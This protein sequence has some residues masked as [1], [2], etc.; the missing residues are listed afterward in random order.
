MT[1]LMKSSPAF[2][3]DTNHLTRAVLVLFL[4]AVLSA[5]GKSSKTNGFVVIHV[6]N[7]SIEN[8]ESYEYCRIQ[9]QTYP[10][11]RRL[12]RLMRQ[13]ERRPPEIPDGSNYYHISYYKTE[14]PDVAVHSVSIGFGSRGKA[15]RLEKMID[16]A[17]VQE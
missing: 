1:A 3:L 7:A 15:R 6:A 13:L 4:V 9:L 14:N 5:C 16:E 11:A 8:F 2:R 10:R 12:V 17:C